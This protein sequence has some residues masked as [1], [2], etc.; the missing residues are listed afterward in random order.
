MTGRDSDKG[1]RYISALENARCQ[2]KWDEVPELIRKVTK[3]A[4]QKTCLLEVAS[5]EYQIASHIQ[6]EASTPQSTSTSSSLQ[7]LL[8]SLLSTI[9]RA[10]GS[11]QEVLQ[12]QVCLGW[13]HWTLNELT[14]ATSRFPDNFTETV[15]DLES[16]GEELSPWTQVCLVKAC[17]LKAASQRMVSD[18]GDALET[19]E[20]LTPW[21]SSHLQGS[22]PGNPQFLYWSEKLLAE[23]ASITAEDAL[24]DIAVT[25]AQTV[26][27]A[28]GFLRLW[29]SHPNT[30]QATASQTAETDSSTHAVLRSSLWKS[31]YDLLTAI[32][33]HGVPY[34]PSTQGPARP[35]LASEIRRVEAICE[36]NLLR[37]TKFPAANSANPQVEEW[38]EEVISNW[39]VLGGPNW[40]DEELGEGGQNAVGRNVLDILYRAATKTYH[41][42]L[43]LR[44]LF[45][46]HCALGDS[47]LAIKALDSYIEI[48]TSAKER[49]EKGAESGELENDGTLLRTIVEGVTM[50]CCFGSKKEAEKAKELTDLLKKFTAKHVQESDDQEDG[51]IVIKPETSS[52]NSQAVSPQD[53]AAAYRGIGTGLANWA[54]WTPINEDRDDIRAEA[55]DYLDKS[56]A[57]ELEDESNRSSLY[58]LALLLA[59]N[60]DIDGAIEFVRSALTSETQ[61]RTGQADFTRERE[62]VPLWHLLALLLSA[63]EDFDIA[64]RSCEAAFEQ[65]PST[66]TSLAHSDRPPQ[67]HHHNSQDQAVTGLTHA[68]I[69][70]LRDREKERIIGTRM[71]Q[72]AFVELLEGPE[73]A[74]NHSEQLLSLFATLFRSLNLES[75]DKPNNAPADHLVPPKSSAGTVKSLRGSIFGRHHRGTRTKGEAAPDH[76]TQ[77]DA[78]PSLQ[79]SNDASIE[80]PAVARSGSRK[81]RSR[82][83]TLQKPDGVQEQAPNHPTGKNSAQAGPDAVPQPPSP[84]MVGTAITDAVAQPST[85][86]QP[87]GPIPHNLKHN[88]QPPP[89]GHPNQPPVQ[90]TRLPLSYAFD[91]PTRAVTKVAPIQSQKHALSILVDIWLLIAGLYRRASS[92][93]DAHEACEEASKHISHFESLVASQESSARAFRE[94]GWGCPKSCQDLWADLYAE[95]GLLSKAQDRPHEAMEHFEQ[96][97][98]HE[99]DHPNATVGLSNLLLD[100]WDRKIPLEP[101]APGIELEASM[102][103]LSSPLSEPKKKSDLAGSS[104]PAHTEATSANAEKEEEP[105]LLNRIAARDRAYGLLAGLTKRGSSWDNSEA[106]YALSRAYEAEGSIEKLKDVLWWCIELEDRRPI[107]P[108]S[109]IGSGIYVL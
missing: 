81:L 19:L 91:S 20:S 31:Y 105:I 5:A 1:H 27:T 59:E 37:E 65:F 69:D 12:A 106:W 13:V 85:A 28:L 33:Q 56:L 30:K 52:T 4:P 71:T 68:L 107:R 62:L 94:R 44:R 89:T 53:I 18:A 42:H 108:W 46:V 47:V 70:Q 98:R 29:A 50:L 10:E 24:R 34:S 82:S 40:T 104:A 67:K 64:E 77:G 35:Q 87:L 57:P 17:Y 36:A 22:T 21:L 75:E 15:H 55:I 60:R 41:S 61:P 3:H 95:R 38:V 101:P 84:G 16:A 72:L 74:L 88:Q 14:L 25:D 43:I 11:K 92:F 51:T 79:V 32:L 86:K 73:N 26:T 78:P 8:P 97:L 103:P 49:A 96:A 54:Y 7:E 45:H 6:K 109:S 23:G 66:I 100:I 48:V 63:K 102:F 80:N 9:N 83:N 99:M 93:E 2:D 76:T 90:D 39:Q 58:T